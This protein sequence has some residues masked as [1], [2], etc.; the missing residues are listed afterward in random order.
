MTSDVI[1][2]VLSKPSLLTVVEHLDNLTENIQKI[3]IVDFNANEISS[4]KLKRKRKKEILYISVKGEKE[5]NKSIAL[6]I[7]AY[8]SKSQMLTFCD[9]DVL[10]DN[11]YF[12]Q[13]HF[14][15]EQKIMFVLDFV[16][17]T[18]DLT[19]RPAPG[20]CTCR[21]EDFLRVDGY[22]SF[23]KGWG[24]EDRDF[25]MRLSKRG[26]VQK[27]IS[28]GHHISHGDEERL[29]NYLESSILKMKQKNN[30]L[31]SIREKSWLPFGTYRKDI[32]N[33][34]FYEF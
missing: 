29:K 17:E 30:E 7:G 6:N 32:R 27:P 23:Y 9:A 33:T 1:I 16:I 15:T 24:K 22:C 34:L 19:R 18:F 20:I 8:F 13:I 25:L 12:D 3:I 14:E 2:P 11:T 4:E 21:I 31:Y 26:V 10:L 28:F 5:F